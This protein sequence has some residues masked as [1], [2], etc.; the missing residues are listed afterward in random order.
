MLFPKNDE[1]FRKLMDLIFVK[2]PK[3]PASLR[4][5]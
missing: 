2:P 3:M 4:K 5:S 1:E